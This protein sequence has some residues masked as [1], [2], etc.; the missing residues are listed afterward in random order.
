[1]GVADAASAAN[2]ITGATIMT[3]TALA[4]V[5][6]WDLPVRI[7]HWSLACSFAAAYVL[8]ESERL[9]GMHVMFGY[10]VLALITFRLLWGFIGTR[11]ARFASFMF[12]PA[13][14]ARYLRSVARGQPDAHLGHNPAGSYVIYA[15]LAL[16]ALTSATGYCSLN[17][18]GS[19]LSKQLHE[20]LANGW[21]A[22][23]F[24]HVA[25][26]VISSVLHHENLVRAMITG[27]RRTA[28]PSAAS[29]RNS[30]ARIG[31]GLAVAVAVLGF[32]TATLLGGA[33]IASTGTPERAGGAEYRDTDHDG[34]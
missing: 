32:W 18:I 14:T 16:G 6:V 31:V 10:T 25:G 26:V 23:V 2:M 33:D 17:D 7:F 8:S 30:P 12:S 28:A 1:M 9:R 11:Y 24:V 27:Y 19:D 13:V 34:D 4:P 22:L 29:A 21:L 3:E 5:R 15:M 20:A